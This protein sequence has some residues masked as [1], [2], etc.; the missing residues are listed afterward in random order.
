M[1]ASSKE[2]F[3]I[4]AS[5]E[6]GFTLKC[7]HYVTRTSSQM[8][9]TDKNSELSSI[10]W[11][12]WPIAWVFVYEL[13]CS[14]LEFGCSTYHSFNVFLAA[15]M[16]S[17]LSSLLCSICSLTET[18]PRKFQKSGKSRFGFTEKIVIWI[19]QIDSIN[20]L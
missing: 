16:L 7:I 17:I 9:R 5:I 15:D 8:H 6:C 2:F 10:I 1:P 3:N 18:I 12:V 13:R 11:Q 20:F 4:Q 19:F 14:G